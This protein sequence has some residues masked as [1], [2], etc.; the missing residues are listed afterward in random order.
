MSKREEEWLLLKD[1]VVP[2]SLC[3]Q[4]N[5]PI[6]FILLQGAEQFLRALHGPQA[7]LIKEQL[8][9]EPGDNRNQKKTKNV[10][11]KKCFSATWPK[12]SVTPFHT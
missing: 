4:T 1:T 11:Y 5:V 10:R 6:P 2:A 7:R 3:S 9:T 8:K 12:Y